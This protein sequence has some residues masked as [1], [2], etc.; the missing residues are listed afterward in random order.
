MFVLHPQARHADPSEKA[1]AMS[2]C[3]YEAATLNGDWPSLQQ[4]LEGYDEMLQRCTMW[5]SHH[6]LLGLPALC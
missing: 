1:T 6:N 5:Q 4:E 2:P 3:F